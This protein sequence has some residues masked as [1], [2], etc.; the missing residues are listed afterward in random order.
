MVHRVVVDYSNLNDTRYKQ[1]RL[2]S[3]YAYIPYLILRGVQRVGSK[4]NSFPY[5][6]L[7]DKY[8]IVCCTKLA[9]KTN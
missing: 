6:L 9:S 5:F 7:S 8:Y 1:C 3:R 4:L 2:I